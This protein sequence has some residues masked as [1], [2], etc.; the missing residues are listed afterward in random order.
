MEKIALTKEIYS[1]KEDSN[2][3][4]YFELTQK[5][6][7][8]LNDYEISSKKLIIITPPLQHPSTLK[9]D[10]VKA[11][12]YS[13]YPALGQLYISNSINNNNIFECENYDMHL[14]M[15]RRCYNDEK[16]DLDTLIDNIKEDY[17]AYLVGCMF[18]T[19]EKKFI[20]R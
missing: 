18:S 8:L 16:Y 6:R 5:L 2:N 19:S 12:G 9:K 7:N 15:L 13:L 11:K 20:K 3:L 1:L 4:D 17:D 14:D 10:L